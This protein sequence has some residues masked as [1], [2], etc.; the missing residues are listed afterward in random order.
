MTNINLDDAY[1]A[2]L[3]LTKQEI[4]ELSKLK[5]LE[6][7]NK[8]TINLLQAQEMEINNVCKENEII[9][10]RLISQKH[11]VF[12]GFAISLKG[13]NLEKLIDFMEIEKGDDHITWLQHKILVKCNMLLNYLD[14][15][16]QTERFPALAQELVVEEISDNM[17]LASMFALIGSNKEPILLITPP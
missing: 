10:S 4:E 1:R 13:E 17:E 16:V 2:L 8:A 6:L 3:S 7:M 12:F 11:Y 14:F 9:I 5:A 15:L